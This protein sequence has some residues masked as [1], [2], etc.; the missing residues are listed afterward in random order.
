MSIPFNT[1]AEVAAAAG[2][3][4]CRGIVNGSYCGDLRTTTMDHRR[5]FI[6]G[7]TVHFADRRLNRSVLKA[8]CLLA[9]DLEDG[10][11]FDQ[12]PLWEARWRR[13]ALAEQIARERLHVRIPSAYWNLDRWTVRAQLT[14]VPTDHP[15]R[16]QAMA[17][18]RLAGAL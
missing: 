17:W 9:A 16:A 13:C 5:G 8:F 2:V 6:D 12:M 10:V 1:M 14:H 11:A 7:S 15:D 18:T 4:Y 3:P